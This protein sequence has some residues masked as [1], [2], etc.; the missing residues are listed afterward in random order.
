M[1]H[2]QLSLHLQDYKSVLLKDPP[3]EAVHHWQQWYLVYYYY[4]YFE[5]HLTH[6]FVQHHPPNLCRFRTIK[7]PRPS[8]S[9]LTLHPQ[10]L[11]PILLIVETFTIPQPSVFWLFP[12][13]IPVNPSV[14]Q[15]FQYTGSP[16]RVM[17]RCPQ[18]ST[19]P[20][21]RSFADTPMDS[22]MKRQCRRRYRCKRAT[23]NRLSDRLQSSK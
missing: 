8:T 9:L 23:G 17:Q 20:P 10:S 2:W 7:Q 1:A 21:F 14:N 22:N 19:A 16:L 18:Y 11:V 6:S 4:H 15:M 5:Q 12:S 3:M 13:A